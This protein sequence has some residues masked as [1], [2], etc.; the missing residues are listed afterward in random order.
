VSYYTFGYVYIQKGKGFMFKEGGRFE[1]DKNNKYILSHSTKRDLYTFSPGNGD[2]DE[3]ARVIRCMDTVGWQNSR[4]IPPPRAAILPAKHFKELKIEAEPKWVKPYYV[5]T[6]TLEHNYQWG[7]FYSEELTI[8]AGITYFE[9]V[10]YVSPHY[11]G[12]KVPMDKLGKFNRQG[13]ELKLSEA[14]NNTQQY[15]KAIN[16]LNAAILNDPVKIAFYLELIYIYDRKQDLNMII[17]TGKQGLTKMMAV[18]KS[19]QKSDLAAWIAHGYE[20]LKNNEQGKYWRAKSLE[21]SPCPGC[22]Y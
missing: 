5:Y 10:Y 1:I 3:I 18:D 16:V 4:F 13:I 21:Y 20:G 15:D 17:E 19:E 2:K 6:D 22:V 9:K 14:Y 8:P 12:V 11:E 7:C